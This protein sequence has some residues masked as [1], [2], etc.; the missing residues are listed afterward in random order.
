MVITFGESLVARLGTHAVVKV[1]VDDELF[2]EVQAGAIVRA[3]LEAARILQ[4]QYIEFW[5]VVGVAWHSRVGPIHF[6]RKLSP[7]PHDVGVG[8]VKIRNLRY[9]GT[10]IRV[11]VVK[12]EIELLDSTR[13]VT[14]AV[15]SDFG[16][17]HIVS[18]S[19]VVYLC[20][21]MQT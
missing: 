5:Y 6:R 4:F 3:C 19:S 9:E 1:I 16:I 8:S 15:S 18:Q 21:G 20:P 11:P 17:P 10:I 14:A 2:V 13:P 12:T 7:P